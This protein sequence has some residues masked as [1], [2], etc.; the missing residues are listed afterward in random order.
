MMV[1][2]IMSRF[3]VVCGKELTGRQLVLCSDEKCY[4]KRK[5]EYLREYRQNNSKKIKECERRYRLSNHE[6]IKK[7][8]CA[9]QR[10]YYRNNPEKINE[11]NRKNYRRVRGL[12][13]D[14][15][16]HKESSIERIMREWLQ[17][18]NIKFV[19]E[20]SINFGNITWTRVDFYISE[21]NICLYCDGNY[22]HSFSKVQERDIRNNKILEKL[23]YNVIRM[24]ETDIL[25]RGKCKLIQYLSEYGIDI[26]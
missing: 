26:K 14:A 10:E 20:Y 2:I 15:D 16:L 22:W 12:P 7:R 13:E 25:E 6:R 23:G 5:N 1:G 24:T 19:Q 3:C 4:K 11:R 8:D 18:L 17:T 9:T 21:A